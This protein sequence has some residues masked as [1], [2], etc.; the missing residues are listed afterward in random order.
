[1]HKKE[2][3]KLKTMRTDNIQFEYEYTLKSQI[4]DQFWDKLG[5]RTEDRF[6]DQT[7]VHLWVELF[8]EISG[9]K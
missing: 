5:D 7:G 1:M 4:G 8:E 2:R 9:R 3:L 6:E